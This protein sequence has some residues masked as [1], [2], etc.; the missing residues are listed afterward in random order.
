MAVAAAAR[1][2]IPP[3]PHGQP[4]SFANYQAL[5]AGS[6][7]VMYFNAIKN[8]MHDC[9][10]ENYVMVRDQPWLYPHELSKRLI[11]KQGE[12]YFDFITSVSN[13]QHMRDAEAKLVTFK[14]IENELTDSNEDPIPDEPDE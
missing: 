8:Y 2:H 6:T 10:R 13:V 5:Y 12:M 9:A 1:P 4:C 3:I 7:A 11:L 14:D